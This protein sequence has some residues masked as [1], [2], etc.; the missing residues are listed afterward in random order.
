LK[1][2]GIDIPGYKARDLEDQLKQNDKNR[3][4]KLSFDEF[5]A[6]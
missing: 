2:V 1:A 4:G 5:E 6:V 3:D